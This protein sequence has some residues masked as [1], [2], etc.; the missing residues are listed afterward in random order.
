MATLCQLT[1]EVG[2]DARFPELARAWFSGVLAEVLPDLAAALAAGR[3]LY[4]RDKR[5]ASV[6][7]LWGEP[8][9]VYAEL[10]VIKKPDGPLA[11]WVQYSPVAWRRFLDGM[12]G[13]PYGATIGIT[14]LDERG[15]PVSHEGTAD[16]QVTRLRNDPR[17]ATFSFTAGAALAGPSQVAGRWTAFARE[18]AAAMHA[19]YADI[20][21]PA[22]QSTL[23][24][25]ATRNSPTKTIP[26]SRTRLR[27]YSWAT[28]VP[29][30]L[31]GKLGGI[32]ALRASGA[33]DQVDEL[34]YGAAWLQAT[35]D[36]DDYD[37]TRA[38]AVFDVLA[39]VLIGGRAER[40]P[41]SP[42]RPLAF[43]VNADDY[44]RDDA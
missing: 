5:D 25:Y 27:G 11:R 28:L 23:L 38:R 41:G 20:G 4:K 13:Y 37:Q 9:A 33:F 34:G 15:R 44:R 42:D 24:E 35:D 22:S 19:V 3:A 16:V 40:W 39:P 7:T 2:E 1:A 12:S 43:D 26:R 17:W 6:D 21:W 14:P 32:G 10:Q 30:E 36:P 31:V 29:P 18:Q 8:H